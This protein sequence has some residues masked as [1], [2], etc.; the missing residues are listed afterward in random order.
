MWFLVPHQF[1]T[2]KLVFCVGKFS[3]LHLRLRSRRKLFEQE[4]LL[5]NTVE[6]SCLDRNLLLDTIFQFLFHQICFLIHLWPI[7]IVRFLFQNG[8][9]FSFSLLLSGIMIHS[10]SNI[11]KDVL[12]MISCTNAYHAT[13]FSAL[14]SIRTLFLD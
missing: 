7:Y 14:F 2:K 6:L 13:V 10:C 11:S 1:R 3:Q 5:L 9:L 12:L 8:L 4:L